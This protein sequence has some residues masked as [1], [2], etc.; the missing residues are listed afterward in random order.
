MESEE[1]LTEYLNER[2]RLIN[3]YKEASGEV[4]RELRVRIEAANEKVKMLLDI[5]LFQELMKKV[6][7]TSEEYRKL[8][9]FHWGFEF[10]EIFANGKG[11]SGFDVVIGNPPYVRQE[12]L[13]DL[14]K[15]LKLY[16]EVYHGVADL[17]T[18]FFEI[19][20]ASCRERV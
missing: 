11:G 17:Y 1:S 19:G 3:S 18:Y 13:G 14:K 2:D 20:R 9:P 6:G 15:I 16:Y 10:H 12:A 8:E 5:R 7:I 4:A